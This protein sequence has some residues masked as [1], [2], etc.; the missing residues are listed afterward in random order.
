MGERSSLGVQRRVGR[1]RGKPVPDMSVV[2][3]EKKKDMGLPCFVTMTSAADII[4]IPNVDATSISTNIA[5]PSMFA[6]L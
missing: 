5:A 4:P 1:S 2:N 3:V 6:P